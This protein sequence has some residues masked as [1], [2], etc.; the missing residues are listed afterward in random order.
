MEFRLRFRRKVGKD[1]PES[2]GK[3]FLEKVLVNKRFYQ[4]QKAALLGC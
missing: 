3:K 1:K 2:S 4:M